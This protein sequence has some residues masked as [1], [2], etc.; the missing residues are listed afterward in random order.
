MQVLQVQNEDH[1]DYDL[2][3]PR[4]EKRRE[5]KK[6]TFRNPDL[7][8]KVYIYVELNQQC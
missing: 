4:S 3:E 5:E 8:E 1:R 2:P 6:N 7:R